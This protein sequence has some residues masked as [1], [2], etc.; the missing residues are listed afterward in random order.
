MEIKVDVNSN[1]KYLL[2]E[3]VVDLYEAGEI[4]A[5]HTDFVKGIVENSE[6]ARP[7]VYDNFKGTFIAY[8]KGQETPQARNNITVELNDKISALMQFYGDKFKDLPNY[9]VLKMLLDVVTKC[10]TLRLTDMQTT[11]IL[12]EL[13]SDGQISKIGNQIILGKSQTEAQIEK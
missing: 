6:T 11:K 7:V 4:D 1:F 10:E 3:E 8:A 9:L 5:Q 2:P 13:G 12:S